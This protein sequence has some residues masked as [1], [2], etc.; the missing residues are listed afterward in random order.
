MALKKWE[1][2]LTKLIII[3]SKL[4]QIK[5]QSLDSFGEGLLVHQTYYRNYKHQSVKFKKRITFCFV[6]ECSLQHVEIN[7]ATSCSGRVIIW[8]KR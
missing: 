1:V 2:K 8:S 7:E 6:Q 3:F 4:K 5:D